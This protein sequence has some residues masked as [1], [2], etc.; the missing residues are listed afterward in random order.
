RHM[1]PRALTS[2][3]CLLHSCADHRRLHSFPTRR[4]SDLACATTATAS[5][6]QRPLRCWCRLKASDTAESNGCDGVSC[7][8]PLTVRTNR[9]GDR[10]STR[11]NSSHVKISYAVFCLKKKKKKTTPQN[12]A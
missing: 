11:L 3:F 6:P 8:R 10:K 7:T 1:C 4:S 9:A 2:F 12:K 5:G